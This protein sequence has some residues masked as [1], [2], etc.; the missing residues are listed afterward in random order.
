MIPNVP[1]LA[2][3]EGFYHSSNIVTG[4]VRII[5]RQAQLWLNG[6][7]P[8]EPIGDCLFR[9]AD[10]PSSPETAE[11]QHLIDGRTQLLIIT[12]EVFR[13]LASS[14]DVRNDSPSSPKAHQKP[15]HLQQDTA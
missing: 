4:G 6:G 9:F 15:D 8:V 14:V 7:T 10:E 13:R 11:F 3:F 2:P 1:E 12:G 5:Q